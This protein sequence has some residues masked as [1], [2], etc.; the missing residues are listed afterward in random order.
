MPPLN[1]LLEDK[2]NLVWH[3]ASPQGSD[4]SLEGSSNF[5][6]DDFKSP[7]SSPSKDHKRARFGYEIDVQMCET[8]GRDEYSS[9]EMEDCWYNAA[10]YARF[11]LDIFE[12]I[13]ADKNDDVQQQGDVDY[14]MRGAEP[15]TF[16]GCKR[17][18]YLRS[19]ACNTVLQEQALQ[20]KNNIQDPFRLSTMY[21]LVVREATYDAINL[22]AIDRRDAERYHAEYDLFVAFD[23]SWISSLSASSSLEFITSTNEQEN[24]ATILDLTS[25]FDDSWLS[26]IAVTSS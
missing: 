7:L 25:G 16:D 6:C 18:Q 8:Y 5:S 21:S 19:T 2:E 4:G 12:S 1:R 3:R 9:K 20:K 26:D 15:K 24:D 23:D 17:R 13:C 10:E 11:R 22:A 14:T